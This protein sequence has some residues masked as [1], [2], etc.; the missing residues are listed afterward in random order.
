M[1]TS[2]LGAAV[3]RNWKSVIAHSSLWGRGS[4]LSAFRFAPS[5]TLPYVFR[6]TWGSSICYW[7]IASASLPYDFAPKECLFPVR[8]QVQPHRT[9]VVAKF[10]NVA[11]RRSAPCSQSSQAVEL[12][13]E[14]AARRRAWA[15]KSASSRHLSR[16]RRLAFPYWTRPLL[17]ASSN[18]G[19]SQ[20]D[21][22]SE[23]ENGCADPS[24]ARCYRHHRRAQQAHL[25]NHGLEVPDL[26]DDCTY[27]HLRHWI[28]HYPKSV[29]RR[30]L[31]GYQ[32]HRVHFGCHPTWVR[33]DMDCSTFCT[34]WEA[35]RCS[36]CGTRRSFAVSPPSLAL[37]SR[38]SAH[39]LC[40]L[41]FVLSSDLSSAF[42]LSSPRSVARV[43]W[44]LAF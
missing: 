11:P 42:A 30:S 35:L 31:H 18:F 3:F 1:S 38:S 27:G 17:R 29:A 9:V 12:Q 43:S 32:L 26:V 40:S 28:L 6:G 14:S 25:P 36:L 4:D 13:A 19:Q 44:N 10:G 7:G 15:S 8:K 39:S 5:Q 41:P 21:V 34:H 2:T 23:R 16:S 20:D 37:C 24:V 33:L 22:H